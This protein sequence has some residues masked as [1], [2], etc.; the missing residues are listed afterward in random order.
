MR[1]VVVVFDED[2]VEPGGFQ[3]GQVEK[4]SSD[5]LRQAGMCRVSRQRGKVDHP[6]QR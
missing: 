4:R 6:D 3:G 5:E 1:L 2:G